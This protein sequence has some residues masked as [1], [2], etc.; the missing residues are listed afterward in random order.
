MA[1]KKMIELT[2]DGPK[3]IFYF[4][5]LRVKDKP[6]DPGDKIAFPR[7]YGLGL[8]V[9]EPHNWTCEEDVKSEVAQLRKEHAENKKKLRSGKTETTEIPEKKSEKKPPKGGEK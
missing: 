6:A 3:R 7:Q 1:G 8:L 5:P 2:M 4:D 9:M